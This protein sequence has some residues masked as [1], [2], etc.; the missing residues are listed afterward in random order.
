[1]NPLK[2]VLRLVASEL[3]SAGHGWALIGG[4][5]ISARLEPRFTRDIDL[6]ISVDGDAAA[7]ALVGRFRRQGFQIHTILEQEATKLISERGFNRGKDLWEALDLHYLEY[8]LATVRLQTSAGDEGPFVDLLFASSGIEPEV[9]EA[10]D[11]I[12]LS[13]GL[14]VPVAQ[15]GHLL[16]MKVLARDDERRPQDLVDIRNILKVAD[17]Q[18]LKRARTALTLISERGFNRGKDLLGELDSLRGTPDTTP[19][20]DD[21]NDP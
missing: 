6:A 21:A 9:V 12:E 17:P 11:P 18:E 10:A 16:A 3:G 19:S 15:L 8:R 14:V 2:E 1:M 13:P 7:E 4:L 5:A 20:T